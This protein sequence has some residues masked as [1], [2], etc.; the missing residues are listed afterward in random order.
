MKKI[1]IKKFCLCKIRMR[2]IY[3]DNFGL[4]QCNDCEFL[5]RKQPS[6][7][8]FEGLKYRNKNTYQ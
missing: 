1:E 4:Q 7:A 3:E 2:G 8:N 6:Y 5:L